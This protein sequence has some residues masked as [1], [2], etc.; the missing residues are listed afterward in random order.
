MLFTS[1]FAYNL[2]EILVGL[3]SASMHVLHTFD[4]MCF[5]INQATS[6]SYQG[7]SHSWIRI[8]Q[9]GRDLVQS[10]IQP[11][12]EISVG[13][14]V[15]PR[16]SGL[17]PVGSGRPPRTVLFSFL[18]GHLNCTVNNI[19]LLLIVSVIPCVPRRERWVFS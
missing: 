9:V 5:A 12:G 15:R 7:K 3:S 13:Y 16:G 4:P 10:V 17:C 2:D 1:N 8:N 14:G 18:L 19:L 6:S 11:L